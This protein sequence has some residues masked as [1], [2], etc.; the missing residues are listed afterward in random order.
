MRRMRKNRNDNTMMIFWE[1]FLHPN[2]S[3]N[4]EIAKRNDNVIII[5]GNCTVKYAYC[6]DPKLIAP[7]V[8]ADKSGGVTDE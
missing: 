5:G 6:L 2:R 7:N 4:S 3:Y 8:L 1:R